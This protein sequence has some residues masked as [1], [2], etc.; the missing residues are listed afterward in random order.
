MVEVVQKKDIKVVKELYSSDSSKVYRTADGSVLKIF[1]PFVFKLYNVA[2]VSLEEKIVNSGRI[3]SLPEVIIPTAA[4]YDE[5]KFIGYTMKYVKGQTYNELEDKLTIGQRT[6]LKMYA[7]IYHKLENIV[8]RGNSKGIIFPDLCT[9]DNIIITPDGRIRL[10]DYDGLQI[11]KYKTVGI[12][13]NIG[14]QSQYLIP[15]YQKDF[16]FNS[17]LDKKSLIELYF[18]DAFNTNIEI[19]GCYNPFIG[20]RITLDDIFENLGLED[21]DLKHKVWKCFQADVDND[22]LGDDVDRIADLYRLVIL[23]QSFGK[24]YFKKLVKKN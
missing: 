22:F 24:F 2:G 23:P 16:L 14:E 12:S 15:K 9:T 17:N 19:V 18:L 13:S 7:H 4:V 10:I 11:G 5:D 8:S 1:T 20:R 21:D 3:E 6:N